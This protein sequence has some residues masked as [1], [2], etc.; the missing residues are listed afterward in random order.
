MEKNQPVDIF[1]DWDVCIS[2]PVP[3]TTRPYNWLYY[4]P[5]E[6]QPKD[7]ELGQG[8]IEVSIQWVI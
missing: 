6:E 4:M 8:F 7:K 1:G 2:P 3:A 5:S